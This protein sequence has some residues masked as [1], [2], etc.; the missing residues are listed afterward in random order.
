MQTA[1][2]PDLKLANAVERDTM[3]A[4][5]A[6]WLVG[7]LIGKRW[8]KAREILDALGLE[9]TEDNARWVRKVVTI[10]NQGAMVIFSAPGL[11]GFIL[12]NEINVQ[13][14]KHWDAAQ[15]VAVKDAAAKLV[16]GR[17]AFHARQIVV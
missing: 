17:R 7:W 1:I 14:F 11:P 9:Y 8:R 5:A 3:S 16:A 12:V 10:A 13:E 6:V 15:L 2:Q 4:D